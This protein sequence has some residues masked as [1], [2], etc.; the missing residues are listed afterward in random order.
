MIDTARGTLL[1]VAEGGRKRTFYCF[2]RRRFA[3][4]FRNSLFQTMIEAIAGF[5]LA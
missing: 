2:G 1:T 5:G 3:S 4:F